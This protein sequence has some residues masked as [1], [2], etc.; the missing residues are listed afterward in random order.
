MNI[1]DWLFQ[2]A[3][4]WPDRPAIY[5]GDT[6]V[7]DYGSL[8]RAVAGRAAALSDRGIGS[9]DR[10]A[11]FAKNC[12]EYLEWLH[13]AWWVGAAVVPIN[14]KLNPK[15]AAW[16][17][18]DAEAA[19]VVTDSGSL[20]T[21]LPEATISG[22]VAASPQATR[23]QAMADGDLA[24]LFYTSG[25]TGR[26]KGVM[27]SHENLRQMTLCYAMDVCHPRPDDHMVYAAPMSHGA[28]LYMFAQSRVGGAH[29]VPAS[30]GFDSDEIIALAQSRGNLVFFAAPTM[31]K[32][33]VTRAAARGYRGDGI[34]TIVY[35]GGPMYGNDIDEALAAFGARFAQIYGQGESPMTISV[36]PRDVVADETHPRWRMRRES[37]GFTAG[38]VTVSIRDQDNRPL[39]TGETGEICVQ[40][41]VVMLGYWRNEGAT[42]ETMQGGC[43]H[44][45]DLGHMDEDGFLYLT[46]RSRDVIISGGTNIYPREVEEVLLRHPAVFEVAI[47]GEREPD[48]GEQVVAFVAAKP[49]ADVV[50]S[51]LDAWCRDNI[52][53][54][55]RPKRYVFMPS[56]PK[57]GY[58]KILKSD[59]RAA[60]PKMG[61]PT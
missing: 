8:S 32:R 30:R 13:A 49:G 61:A 11:V 31:V 29:L 19:L 41:P 48:W 22:P 9:G 28:G 15:E 14:C 3:R 43:L 18:R 52:A 12:P 6:L 27:L 16:I 5:C 47:I 34:R 38:C 1:A 51:D 50:P 44:T 40:G 35:G 36:L 39:P 56:L 59:L 4:T 53:A 45:G 21:D 33:L 54:F 46:D 58:G 10:V 17:V 55:K 57:N 42:A 60:L 2:A 26:P 25:T 24:W 7:H 37:V 23:P 20:F